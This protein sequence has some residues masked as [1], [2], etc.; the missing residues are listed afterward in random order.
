[1]TRLLHLLRPAA[2][3]DPAATGPKDVRVH[4]ELDESG[5]P[6]YVRDGRVVNAAAVIEL[7]METDNVIVW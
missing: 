3:A 1:M 7:I 5:A 2:S 6:V 4:V